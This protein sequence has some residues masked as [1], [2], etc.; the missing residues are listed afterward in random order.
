MLW[1]CMGRGGW[2]HFRFVIVA[3]L[4]SQRQA[5]KRCFF[6]SASPQSFCASSSICWQSRMSSLIRQSILESWNVTSHTVT[7]KVCPSLMGCH[8]PWFRMDCFWHQKA[9][10]YPGLHWDKVTFN[11]SLISKCFILVVNVCVCYLYVCVRRVGH[12]SDKP[13]RER[14][15]I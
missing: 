12:T 9:S 11:G 6:Q 14:S 4:L 3:Y 2:S 1:E 13:C 10:L 7:F 8:N 15:A 5:H